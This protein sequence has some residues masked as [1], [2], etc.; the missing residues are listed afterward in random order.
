MEVVVDSNFDFVS[1]DYDEK[2]VV[3]TGIGGPQE[4]N[5]IFVEKFY[6]DLENIPTLEEVL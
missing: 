1:I 5:D 3:F 4:V 2:Y 6:F